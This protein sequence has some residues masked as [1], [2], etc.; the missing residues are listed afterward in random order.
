MFAF[1]AVLSYKI[2]IQ[3]R[4]SSTLHVHL[5]AHAEDKFVPNVLFDTVISKKNRQH[6]GQSKKYKRT[7]SDL[8]K[9]Q[10]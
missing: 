8:Q 2:L 5:I 9:I 6:N 1:Y 3:T 7:N 10:I 4:R